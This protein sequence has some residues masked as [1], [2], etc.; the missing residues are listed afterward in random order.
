MTQ[1]INK[2]D[3]EDYIKNRYL[4]HQTGNQAIGCLDRMDE[5]K[6]ILSYLQHLKVKEMDL[7]KEIDDWYNTMGIPVTTDALKETA[8]HF[9]ELG[10]KV[11]QKGE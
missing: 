1:Y 2:N 4:E 8:R 5:D 9:F 11:N 7:E 6:E 10:I 3:L